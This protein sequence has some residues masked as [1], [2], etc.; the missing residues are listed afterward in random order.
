MVHIGAPNVDAHFNG[1]FYN[2]KS[3]VKFCGNFMSFVVGIFFKKKLSFLLYENFFFC[4]YFFY[5]FPFIPL[6]PLYD[7]IYAPLFGMEIMHQIQ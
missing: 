1:Y 7:Y 3:N 6:A 5:V 2:C 4:M